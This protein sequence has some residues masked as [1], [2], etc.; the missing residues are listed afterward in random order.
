MT[1]A[2]SPTSLA[3]ALEWLGDGER[4][5]L[6]IA[7]CT[8]LMV[9]DAAEG[10][11]HRSVVDLLR[12]PELRGVRVVDGVMDLGAATTFW[13]LRRDALVA[14]HA[15]VLQE[16]A[17]TIGGWQIQA[18][19]TIGGNIANASPAGDSLPLWLALDAELVLGSVHG[20][21]VLPYAA[22]HTGYRQTALLPGELIVR[23]RVPLPNPGTRHFFRKIGTREAQAI[24]KVVLAAAATVEEGRLRHVRFAVGSVAPTPVRLAPVEEACEGERPDEALADRAAGIAR[25]AV[26]PIDDVRSTASYRRHVLGRVIRRTILDLKE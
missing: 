8:D 4:R 14:R 22:W 2:C 16:M 13:E 21:R 19:A 15:P 18:R 6:P 9:V 26:Q 23:V 20:E 5:A 3:E 7:G 1:E 11:R 10:R 25:A 24:S 17:A 12:V